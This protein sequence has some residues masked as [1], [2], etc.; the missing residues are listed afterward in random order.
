MLCVIAL[1]GVAALAAGSSRRAPRS[2][3]ADERHRPQL[4]LYGDDHRA[5]GHVER[6]CDVCGYD[7]NADEYCIDSDAHS[8]GDRHDSDPNGDKDDDHAGG[9]EDGHDPDDDHYHQHDDGNLVDER[10]LR[11]PR[12]PLSRPRPPALPRPTK[13]PTA[14]RRG[15]DSRRH[16]RRRTRRWRR[17][18]VAA[19]AST[20]HAQNQ[21]R[22]AHVPTKRR[23]VSLRDCGRGLGVARTGPTCYVRVCQTG[24]IRAIPGP[25]G[26]GNSGFL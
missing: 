10:R 12:E 6:D 13:I 26:R 17:D 25:V 16:P 7:H 3:K 21:A 5:G 15:L 11:T 23:L 18:L 2:D 4:L 20:E 14:K 1:A 24:T 8:D 9:D 22:V 19:G